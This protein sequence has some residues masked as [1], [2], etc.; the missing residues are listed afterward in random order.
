MRAER[1]ACPSTPDRIREYGLEVQQRLMKHVINGTTDRGS[2]P[3]FNAGTA[4]TDPQW[5]EAEKREIFRRLP[6][7][8]GLSR[9]IPQPGDKLLFDAVGPSILVVRDK[10][11]RVHA[12]LN[13]CPHRATKLV[14]E[15]RR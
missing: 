12:Y 7:M 4:Y 2:G 9:D 5:F 15:C 8:V 3:M 13:M 1:S 11:H 6:L 14:Q 10:D